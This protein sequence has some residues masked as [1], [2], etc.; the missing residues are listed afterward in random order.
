MN[1][2]TKLLAAVAL[3]LLFI[4]GCT[5]LSAEDKALLTSTRQAADEAKAAAT[6][7][8]AAANKAAASATESADAAKAAAADAAAAAE[9]ANRM[10][11]RTQRKAAG[12]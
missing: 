7:A 12:N 8:E 1:R 5:Q 6:Q 4:G 3:P 11:Q 2:S 9:R 10:F